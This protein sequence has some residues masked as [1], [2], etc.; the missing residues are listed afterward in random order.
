MARAAV[1]EAA[2][3]RSRLAAFRRHPAFLW[4]VVPVGL[5]LLAYLALYVPLPFVRAAWDAESASDG[6]L[7]LR[8]RMADRL[9]STQRLRGM[10]R[11]RVVELLGEPDALTAGGEMVYVLGN[12]RSF[13][14][15][16]SELLSVR[17]DHTGAVTGVAIRTD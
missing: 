17:L 6:P 5:L 15:I 12:D 13:L 11:A 16:D 8:H 2:A 10:S 1:T 7:H 4:T 9:V 3:S 14:G